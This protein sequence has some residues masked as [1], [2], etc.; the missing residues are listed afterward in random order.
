MTGIT[1]F[2]PIS[3]PC[4]TAG[5][6]EFWKL[7]N[8]IDL[9]SSAR[10]AFMQAQDGRRV[11]RLRD[12]RESASVWWGGCADQHAV[13]NRGGGEGKDKWELHCR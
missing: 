7:L 6:K 12:R 5:D 9:G 13:A 1:S 2:T 4:R 8:L 10:R 11:P 3:T